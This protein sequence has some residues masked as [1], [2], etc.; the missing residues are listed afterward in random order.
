MSESKS[1]VEG[2]SVI[3]TLLIG[4]IL[5]LALYGL[6]FNPNNKS[7]VK[8]LSEQQYSDEIN[9]D[10]QQTQIKLLKTENQYKLDSQ[11]A[12]YQVALDEKMSQ[13]KQKQIVLNN[14]MSLVSLQQQ[15]KEA[16]LNLELETK[17]GQIEV[18]KKTYLG[19][20][21]ASFINELPEQ[22]RQKFVDEYFSQD[23]TSSVQTESG[24]GSSYVVHQS[25]Q[26]SIDIVFTRD[27]LNT[28]YS[29]LSSSQYTADCLKVNDFPKEKNDAL[30]ECINKYNI[31]SSNF[32]E[33]TVRVQVFKACLGDNS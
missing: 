24:G 31:D 1:K 11:S 17:K 6:V 25:Q 18:V 12:D 4:V 20:A 9:S 33:D 8:S 19:K 23:V 13:E 27:D 7:T 5:G 29:C 16:E 2:D 10:N 21:I 14:Q 32:V 26:S 30:H 3:I 15:V 22:Y 28:I